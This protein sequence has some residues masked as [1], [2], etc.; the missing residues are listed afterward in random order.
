VN[1]RGVNTLPLYWSVRMSYQTALRVSSESSCAPSTMLRSRPFR[2]SQSI[3]PFNL[4]RVVAV[5]DG[6]ETNAPTI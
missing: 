6:S 5:W 3:G 2:F 4:W 1:M